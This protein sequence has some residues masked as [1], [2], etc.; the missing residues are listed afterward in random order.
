MRHDRLNHAWQG[1][2]KKNLLHFFLWQHV[3]SDPE[4]LKIII[5][6]SLKKKHR[7]LYDSVCDLLE[8]SSHPL[9]QSEPPKPNDSS[10][11]MEP[12]K[13][14]KLSESSNLN[15][16]FESSDS[17][18][19]SEGDKA[20]DSCDEDILSLADELEVADP[21]APMSESESEGGDSDSDEEDEKTPNLALKYFDDKNIDM[22]THHEIIDRMN[23]R[24]RRAPR[25][26]NDFVT[27]SN[28][29]R[30]KRS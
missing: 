20:N 25:A 4:I 14:L 19:E 15:D 24:K 13:P 30:S 29:K 26:L 27:K 12:Y 22:I 5:K 6:D 10:Q 28:A 18:E 7:D 3:K 21:P 1:D 8:D 17:E 23:S 16:S 9:E 11:P 2:L